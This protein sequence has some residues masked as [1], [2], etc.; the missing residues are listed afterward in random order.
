LEHNLN[1]GVGVGFN[2]RDSLAA[3]WPEYTKLGVEN[4]MSATYD[5]ARRYVERGPKGSPLPIW[6][7][8]FL[9]EDKKNGMSHSEIRRV[10]G[11]KDIALKR[12]LF[13]VF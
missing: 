7:V 13:S 5:D 4:A 10:W 2:I 6:A 12:N 8:P 1:L 9:L 11:R 3:R